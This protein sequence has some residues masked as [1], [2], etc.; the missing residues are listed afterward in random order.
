MKEEILFLN[1]IYYKCKLENIDEI[2]YL[3]N[4]L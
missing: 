2:L 4:V 3:K 1:N